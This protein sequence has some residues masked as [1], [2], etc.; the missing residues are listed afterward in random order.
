MRKLK[1]LVIS[2]L[3]LGIF[4]NSNLFV[5]AMDIEGEPRTEE[6][7]Q[8]QSPRFRPHQ[9]TD[10]VQTTTGPLSVPVRPVTVPNTEEAKEQLLKN[11]MPDFSEFQS[12]GFKTGEKDSEGKN[13][14]VNLSAAAHFRDKD[15]REKIVVY[16]SQMPDVVGIFRARLQA[17]HN[18]YEAHREDLLSKSLLPKWLFP[19][20]RQPPKRHLLEFA[21]SKVIYAGPDVWLQN[22]SEPRHDIDGLVDVC[23][24]LRHVLKSCGSVLENTTT[25]CAFIIDV[26][27]VVD[28]DTA[29]PWIERMQTPIEYYNAVESGFYR[30]A[31]S[32]LS[33]RNMILALDYC[34]DEFLHRLNPRASD[35]QT[36]DFCFALSRVDYYLSRLEK[37]KLARTPAELEVMDKLR[38]KIEAL[39]IEHRFMF[40]RSASPILNIPIDYGQIIAQ[41][42]SRSIMF[43][44]RTEVQERFIRR[45][46]DA[47]DT[48][49]S[50]ITRRFDFNVRGH[51]ALKELA[52]ELRPEN[53]QEMIDKMQEQILALEEEEGQCKAAAEAKK[54]KVALKVAESGVKLGVAVCTGGGSEV[55]GAIADGVSSQPRIA[56]RDFTE[57]DVHEFLSAEE[58]LR[59]QQQVFNPLDFMLQGNF[60]NPTNIVVESLPVIEEPQERIDRGFPMQPITVR[61]PNSTSIGR[62]IQEQGL[63][64]GDIDALLESMNQYLKSLHIRGKIKLRQSQREFVQHIRNNEAEYQNLF[65]LYLKILRYNFPGRTNFSGA[66]IDER[67]PAD[68][69]GRGQYL[70][71]YFVYEVQRLESYL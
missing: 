10:I 7:T 61:Q 12:V 56:D 16:N 33:N 37:Y 20:W 25:P 39:Y 36:I 40:V 26:K 47:L 46:E 30:I 65:L 71:E 68:G 32:N 52:N 70:R 57:Q 69:D 13:V 35:Q 2:A 29:R 63:K 48:R 15:G 18:E 6:R 41:T 19:T 53:Y 34:L 50:T 23:V 1:P 9:Q 49:F 5:Q 28:C 38:R 11:Y 60:D 51:D 31:N 55:V 43:I 44:D 58:A 17:K 42:D 27:A 67:K 54:T 45:L 22:P 4:L 8:E 62:I 64:P 21:D 66:I 24:H 59:T 14:A 3:F